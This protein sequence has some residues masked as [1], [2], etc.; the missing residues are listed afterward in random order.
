MRLPG[1]EFAALIW[2]GFNTEKIDT[3]FTLRPSARNEMG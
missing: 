2:A 3:L 1:A